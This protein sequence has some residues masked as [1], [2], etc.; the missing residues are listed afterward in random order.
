MVY[1]A[2]GG[3]EG[4]NEIWK[5]SMDANFVVLGTQEAKEVAGM[6]TKSR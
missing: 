3:I 6:S 1:V 5:T 4:L 2:N